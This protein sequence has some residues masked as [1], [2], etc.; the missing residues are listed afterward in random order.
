[1]TRLH[2]RI[3]QGIRPMVAEHLLEREAAQIAENV[4]M[5]SGEIRP[6]DN[7]LLNDNLNERDENVLTI[8]YYLSTYW[9]EWNATVDVVESPVLGDTESRRYYTG[10]GIPKKTNQDEA[11]TGSGA[12]P[13]TWF[14]L[15]V[16]IPVHAPTAGSPG[17]GGSGDARDVSYL[18]TVKTSWGEEGPPSPASDIVSP[19]QEQA[20]ALSAMTLVWQAAQAYVTDSW[21]IPTSIA[22]HV[23]KCTVAGTSAGTEPVFEEYTTIGDTFTDGTVTWMVVDKGILYDSGGVKNIYRANTGT[24]GFQWQLLTTIAM[25]ATT[26]SDTIA[27]ADL[28]ATILP[29]LAWDSPPEGLINITFVSGGFFA[30]SVGKDVYFSEP[31]Q[32]HS[33]PDYRIPLPFT[34]TAIKSI[35]NSVIVMTDGNPYII[36]GTHPDSMTPKRL[37][38]PRACSS[39]TG[40]VE[41]PGGVLYPSEFG[42][43]VINGTTRQTITKD[44]FTNKEWADYY[45][46]TMKA[47]FQNDRLFVFYSS[48][49]NEGGLI[50][51]FNKGI[52]TTLDFY[53]TAIY[54]DPA[55]EK[56]YYVKPVTEVLLLEGGTT[57]PSR[58]NSVLLESGDK[59][60][61]E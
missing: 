41:F 60:L 12:Y 58:T 20:V 42:Y 27:D 19:T 40:V 54:V 36:Y 39:K 7:E 4:N 26:Y 43:E 18:W 38:D 33:W 29:S 49:D 13:I 11:T 52:V 35:G 22:S 10:D 45:P 48:G 44:I 50:F 51:N 1:M 57:Y 15:Q 24:T 31:F 37:P 46:S 23:Y 6:W 16:P 3:R 17:A 9:F 14:P 28:E 59:L 2:Y 61:L 8:Y 47:A 30:G 25:A 5:E 34:V 32:P 21:V 56:L 53:A 55:T